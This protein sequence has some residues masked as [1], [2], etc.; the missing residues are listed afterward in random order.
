M[1]YWIQVLEGKN[2]SQVFAS[3]VWDTQTPLSIFGQSNFLVDLKDEKIVVFEIKKDALFCIAEKKHIKELSEEEIVVKNYIFRFLQMEQPQEVLEEDVAAYRHQLIEIPSSQGLDVEEWVYRKTQKY[4]F[5]SGTTILVLLF[6]FQ[7]F[8]SDS[9]VEVI[10]E[11]PAPKLTSVKLSGAPTPSVVAAAYEKAMMQGA[12][13]A[14]RMDQ[15]TPKEAQAAN[16]VQNLKNAFASLMG[17]GLGGAAQRV[18][19]QVAQ[20]AVAL[21][22]GVQGRGA[23]AGSVGRRLGAD[24]ESLVQIAMTGSGEGGYQVGG[25]MAG[26]GVGGVDGQGGGWLSLNISDAMI[27]EGL[28]QDEVGK[29]I[30]AQ[31]SEIRYCYESSMLR[32]P[33]IE[34]KLVI[35]FVIANTGRVRVASVKESS[36]RDERL[37]EC[38]LKR[39]ARW[40]F[41]RP[42]SGV[43][44]AVSY[45]FIF[46]RLRR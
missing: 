37:N 16:P 30:H 43:E 9:L 36:V 27:D 39:L 17:G 31:I 6:S 12:A 35:D 42:K 4:T 26:V 40:E 1:K 18:P 46:K 41:P 29:V 14:A 10:E 24:G 34:G 25:D 2:K 32:K 28:S 5:A 22:P 44:V 21:L 11:E 23:V 13:Q 45:P 20:A 3:Y 15:K 7:M 19:G 8:F 33:E 38:I